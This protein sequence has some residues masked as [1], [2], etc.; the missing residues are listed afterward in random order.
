M[1]LHDALVLLLGH[2][3]PEERSIPES[4]DYPGRHAEV[5]RALNSALQE[6]YGDGAPWMRKGSEGFLLHPPQA[7][8]VTVTAGGKSAD[9][10]D[11][12]QDWF[13]GCTCRING[14]SVDNVITTAHEG[15]TATLLFP[16]DGPS[17][18]AS[19][20]IYHDSLTLPATVC[21]VMRPVSVKG[22]HFLTPVNG[23][24]KLDGYL[25]NEH[26]YDFD[27]RVSTTGAHTYLP[28]GQCLGT[29]SLYTVDTHT[30]DEMASPV[31]RLRLSPAPDRQ[32]LLEARVQYAAPDLS[33]YGYDDVLPVPFQYAESILLP[34]ATQILSGSPFFR[35]TSA[36]GEIARQYSRALELAKSS[37]PQAA[38]SIRLR[39]IH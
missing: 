37:T 9:F 17:G 11:D 13:T 31:L 35:N 24:A 28:K 32:M 6:L 12:W 33:N 23:P 8:T 27:R 15:G 14:A 29:P 21:N 4:N 34:I 39:S 18:D 1:T 30:A 10:G 5:T 2:F 20:T 19:V 7:A 22:E 36:A 16:H 38:S 3:A 25:A 26:D